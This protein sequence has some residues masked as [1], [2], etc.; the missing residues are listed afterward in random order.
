MTIGLFHAPL[1][2]PIGGAEMD[3]L[4]SWNEGFAKAA[5]L[6]FVAGATREGGPD[7]VPPPERIAV[8]DHDGTLWVERPLQVQIYFT[9][10]RLAAIA[11]R[12]PALRE[13]QPYKAFLE[14]DLKTIAGF[15]RR[16]AFEVAFTMHS[17][18][19]T[20]EFI[21][22]AASWLAST[23]H[24]TLGRLFTECVYQPQ[25]E[26]LTFLRSNGFKPFV[27]TGGGI[28]F[29]R[30]IAERLYGIPPEQV[31]GSSNK[32]RV[33]SGPGG[34]ALFKLPEVRSFDDREEKV[35]NIELHIG[36]RPRLAFGNSDG[37]LRMLQYTGRGPGPRL[38]LLLHHDDDVRE[39]SYDREFRLSP[40]DEALRMAPAEGFIV[41]SIKN[42]WKAVFPA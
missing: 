15:S 36:R 11:A 5:I 9:L 26:L 35:V 40:L 13:R 34:P 37:D 3:P 18:L 27:V 8:F 28:E 16:E 38:R 41:V 14:R 17:V 4:P 1:H 21:D 10:D 12:D 39:F 30:Y 32:T 25:L 7:F 29:V 24:P 33:E 31:V 6:D 19:T 2:G 23:K 22:A 42:D 20:K